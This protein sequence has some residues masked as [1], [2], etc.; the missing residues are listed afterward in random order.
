MRVDAQR[1]RHR[2]ASAWPLSELS[3]PV[4]NL[5]KRTGAG[6]KRQLPR[7][8]DA[9]PLLLWGGFCQVGA[10][11]VLSIFSSFSFFVR[12]G[13]RFFAPTHTPSG[14]RAQERS[15]VDGALRSSTMLA[16]GRLRSGCSHVSGLLVQPFST[17]AGLD[18]VREAGPDQGCGLDT[19]DRWKVL[20][21]RRPTDQHHAISTSATWTPYGVFISLWRCNRAP[22]LRRSPHR[23]ASYPATAHASARYW[24]AR[25]PAS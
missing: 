14:R 25:W 22:P 15:C 16:W 6:T 5:F 24:G 17:A 13:S 18:V 12:P 21:P 11:R 19:R 3:G 7:I 8:Y 20:P 9:G 10:P 2:R 1:P 23:Q 4:R